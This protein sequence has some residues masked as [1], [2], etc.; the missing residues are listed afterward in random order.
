MHPQNSETDSEDFPPIEFELSNGNLVKVA[1][2]RFWTRITASD[3][4]LGY[5]PQRYGA[6]RV[7]STEGELQRV[8]TLQGEFVAEK[9]FLPEAL[10][11]IWDWLEALVANRGHIEFDW[12]DDF[13][14]AFAEAISALSYEDE[15]AVE[16]YDQLPNLIE[17]ESLDGEDDSICTDESE[18]DR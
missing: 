18:N 7:Y 15:E 2:G 13:L 12:C 1:T 5:E 11:K 10:S 16:H 6:I 8:L 3:K 17:P 9:D 14:N 4:R